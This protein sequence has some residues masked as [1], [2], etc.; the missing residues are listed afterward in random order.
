[1]SKTHIIVASEDTVYYWQYR[2]KNANLLE[3]QSKK[4]SGKENAF[5]I[6]EQ[7]RTDGIY[8]KDRWV[9]P[10]RNCEDPITAIA[11]STDSFLVGRMSGEVLKFS[12]PYIQMESK[13]LL[14]CCPHQLMMNCDG[15]KYSIIDINGMLTFYDMND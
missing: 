1:M 8:D 15:T 10:D 5:H 9:K 7:P 13:M 12:L 14:R 4:K 3:S 6:D 11:V 2:Q